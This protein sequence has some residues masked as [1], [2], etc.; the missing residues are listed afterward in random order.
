MAT[1]VEGQDLRLCATEEGYVTQITAGTT[2][3][4]ATEVSD[5]VP[6]SELEPPAEPQ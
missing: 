1:T 2:Q 6:A 5:E 4:L 3:A